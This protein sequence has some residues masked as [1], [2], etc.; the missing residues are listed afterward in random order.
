M[1]SIREEI[2]YRLARRRLSRS[3]NG[4]ASVPRSCEVATYGARRR[5]ELEKQFAQHCTPDDVRDQRVLDF[6]CARGALAF[7]VAR[8]GALSVVGVDI[9]AAYIELARA[10][11]VEHGLANVSFELGTP[12]HIPLADASVDVVL[13]FD[14][15]EHV[16][17]YRAVIR[18]WRR[19]L[20]TGGRVLI[21]WE[22][23]YHP[24]GHHCYAM[25]PLPWVHVA[26]SDAALMRVCA[27]VYD[28]PEFRPRFW[29]LD[30]DGRKKPNP[31]AAQSSLEDY[32]NKLTT[33]RFDRLARAV[34]FRIAHKQM[35]PFGGDRLRRTK[36]AL[37]ALPFLSDFFSARVIYDLR[38][39]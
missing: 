19:V 21:S 7:L 36:R 5:S 22:T 4:M 15:M 1:R 23:W 13:C 24:Y 3:G 26:L 38:A 17:E 35:V 39:E 33:W 12:A 31:Y 10:A 11:A 29:H 25:I 9:S 37:A 32:V 27:R 8:A 2:C 14:V 30:A 18:E 16:L 20:A 6:G 28:L 34:G